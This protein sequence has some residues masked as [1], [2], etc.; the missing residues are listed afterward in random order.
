MITLVWARR[1][2]LRRSRPGRRVTRSG[3]VQRILESPLLLVI[4]I[5]VA[6]RSRNSEAELRS[7]LELWGGG[8]SRL[9]D[10]NSPLYPL[11]NRIGRTVI[12]PLLEHRRA[13]PSCGEPD[14]FAK[15]QIRELVSSAS[16]ILEG[17]N[18]ERNT[19]AVLL[20]GGTGQGTYARSAKLLG[21][22]LELGGTVTDRSLA[23]RFGIGK[24]CPPWHLRSKPRSPIDA[25]IMDR[26]SS[27]SRKLND[28]L[29][30][31]EI[32]DAKVRPG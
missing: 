5:P 29:M 27:S 11:R 1:D 22:Q 12:D 7:R 24:I 23:S 17:F 16:P 3:P 28:V 31:S 25:L 15:E 18:V 2:G 21:L 26:L 19:A 20:A 8:I 4:S 13:T 6:P 10:F 30:N 32:F 9:V 14:V